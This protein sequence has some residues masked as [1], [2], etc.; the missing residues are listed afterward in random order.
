MQHLNKL[1]YKGLGLPVYL[2]G[3][4]YNYKKGSSDNFY[5]IGRHAIYISN[6]NYNYG[7]KYFI[8]KKSYYEKSKIEELYEIHNI[9]SSCNFAVTSYGLCSCE[10]G[11]KIQFG[12][13][14]EKLDDECTSK[15]TFQIDEFR[16]F[17][18]SIKGLKKRDYYYEM[19]IGKDWYIKYPELQFFVGESNLR[20]NKKGKPLLID[21]DPRWSLNY[22][23]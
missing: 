14:V 13:I 15:D 22:E 18:Q 1:V 12:L 6:H 3:T 9:L 11:N 2:N 5:E 8:I 10:Y 16:S 4:K 21:I 17:C 20:L 7:F 23:I 19:T